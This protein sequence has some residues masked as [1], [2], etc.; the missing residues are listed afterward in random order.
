MQLR[1][2]ICVRSIFPVSWTLARQ[3]KIVHVVRIEIPQ[4]ACMMNPAILRDGLRIPTYLLVE[5]NVLDV[6]CATAAAAASAAKVVAHFAEN[7]IILT[8]FEAE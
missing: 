5:Q 3:L 2:E 7:V 1:D 4:E 6:V 8:Q